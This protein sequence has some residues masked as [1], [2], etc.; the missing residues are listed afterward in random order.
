MSENSIISCNG[1]ALFAVSYLTWEYIRRSASQW[2]WEK[3]YW[4]ERKGLL[5]VA[6]TEQG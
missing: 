6:I 2:H 4:A 1:I 3:A 5:I